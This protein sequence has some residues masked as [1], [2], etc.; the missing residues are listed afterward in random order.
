MN[1]IRAGIPLA[2]KGRR[3]DAAHLD[4]NGMTSTIQA[5]SNRPAWVTSFDQPLDAK[6]SLEAPLTLVWKFG[7]NPMRA[8]GSQ[9]LHA[10]TVSFHRIF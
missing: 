1:S 7:S 4:R 9:T 8:V 5:N 2:S 6:D 3:S 10:W